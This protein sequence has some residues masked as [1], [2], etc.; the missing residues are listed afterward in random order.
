MTSVFAAATD[1]TV[2]VTVPPTVPITVPSTAPPTTTPDDTPT[3][4]FRANLGE[5]VRDVI[6]NLGNSAYQTGVSLIVATVAVVAMMNVKV[7]RFVLIPTAIGAFWLGWLGWNTIT[8]EDNQLF[9]GDPSA[10]KIW[11]IAFVDGRGFLT[12]VIV[13]CIAAIFLW[14]KSVGTLNRL[15]LL[16]GALVGASFVYNVIAAVRVR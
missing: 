13:G 1:P 2:P 12:A 4:E 3:I 5:V 6:D 8:G 14:R 16:A 7:Q 10:T 15:L 9:P 11:D